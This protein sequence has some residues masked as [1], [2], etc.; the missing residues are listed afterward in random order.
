MTL[1]QNIDRSLDLN[2][3]QTRNLNQEIYLQLDLIQ[4]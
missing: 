3:D 1:P 2:W 4:G